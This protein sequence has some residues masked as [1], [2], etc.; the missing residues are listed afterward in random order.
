MLPEV[1]MSVTILF[2]RGLVFELVRRDLHPGELLR[3][4]GIDDARLNDLRDTLSLEET[5]RIVDNAVALTG[6]PGVGL[7]AGSHTP[8]HTLQLFGH[9]ILAQST[10][11]DVFAAL[12]RYGQLLADG[13]TWSLREQGDQA[14]FCCSTVLPDCDLTRVLMDYTLA[15]S[16]T[17]GR[18]FFRRD[19]RLRAV[20]FRHAAP[21]YAERYVSVFA[22][23]VH[24][25]QPNN[26]TLFDR[27]LMDRPKLHADPAVATIMRESAERMLRERTQSRSLT[28]CVR[29][30]L[31]YERDLATVDV[32]RFSRGLKMSVHTLRRR[33]SAEGTSFSS[34]LDEARRNLACQE[35]ERHDTTIQQTAELLGFS[36]ASAF[37]RAFKRWTGQTP[38][39]YRRRALAPRSDEPQAHSG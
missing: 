37:F 33:L 5:A 28:D 38:N 21:S 15:F 12:T 36:E 4:S 35:L 23:P 10:L 32:R 6:D 25:S 16:C 13:T 11:R 24:F 30:L 8:E 18:H 2:A 39:A 19:E 27:A 31:R 22:C 26:A 7:A 14:M 1:T 3:R 9:L 20:H 34:L 17:I 29:S